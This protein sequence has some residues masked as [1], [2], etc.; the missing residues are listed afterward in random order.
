[1]ESPPDDAELM[2]LARR[3]PAAFDRIYRRHAAALHRA[4]AA[5]LGSDLADDVVAE[6]FAR[7]WIARRRFRDERG[8]SVLP[9][10]W[11]I[12]ANVARESARARRM[13]DLGRRRLRMTVPQREDDMD[14]RAAARL[15]AA[16]RAP[17][18][19]GVLTPGERRAI[20]LRV[21]MELPFSQVAVRL[22]ITTAAAR[23]RVSRG[24]RRMADHAGIDG[25]RDD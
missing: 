7:A 23:L 13:E 15:D 24:L 16:A 21:G 10:L 20:D 22:G 4:L 8:G 17:E 14:D 1:M 6:T 11:G 25:E 19:T 5:R 12:A 18:L 9:W 3:D 2:R